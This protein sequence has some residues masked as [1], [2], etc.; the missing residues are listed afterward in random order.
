MAY[1]YGRAQ[2]EKVEKIRKEYLLR[3]RKMRL[4]HLEWLETLYAINGDDD[5]MLRGDQIV[6]LARIRSEEIDGVR[7]SHNYMFQSLRT[8]LANAM[9]NAP[10]PVIT[11]GRPGRDSRQMARACERLLSYF[12]HDKHYDDAVKTA[13]SWTFTCGIGF[14][15][16]MWDMDAKDPEYVPKTDSDGNVIY[17]TEK[18]VMTGADGQ[19]ALSPY[20]TPLTEDVMIPQGEYKLLGDLKYYAPS[21]FDVF[22]QQVRRWPDVKNVITRSYMNKDTMKDLFGSKAKDLYPDVSTDDFIT[23]DDYD[24]V[25][26]RNRED[27]LVLC[28]SYYERPSLEHPD[29]KYCVIANEKIIYEEDLPGKRLPIFPVYDHESPSH[30]WGESALR[31]AVQV[32]RDINAAES[33]L[34]TDRRMHAHPR[35]VAQ[36]GSL[37]KGVTRVP[38]IP[39]AVM[40]V[41]PDAKFAP[42]F[43]TAPPLPSWVERAPDRLKRVMDD[44]TGTHGVMKGDQKG[45]MSGRQASVIM[46]ADRAK[47]GPTIQ[48]LAAAVEYTS[49][50]ALTLWKEFGPEQETI[51]I[52]G[53]IGT[54][55]DIM[56][57]YRDYLP[58]N[59]RVRIESSQL[60]PYNEEIRRQQINEAWQIGAIPD[61]NMFWKLQ[62]HG[63]MGRLLG[64]DEP[65]RARARFEND[66]LDKGQMMPV[67]QHE[68][69]SVHIDEHLER[70]RDPSWYMLTPQAQQAYRMHV[71]KHQALMQN[72]QNPVL[73][74]KSQMP[75]LVGENMAP[76][77]N[78]AQGAG[79][80]PGVNAGQEIK[81]GGG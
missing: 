3:R 30:L 33:D 56:V 77:M 43:L 64:N 54:P 34:K 22:P 13:L 20:G 41:R 2:D 79:T 73:A 46:A 25:K 40:E 72:V 59:I 7:V 71:A 65:S 6:D 67:E 74:G 57:F 17:K 19:M 36:Q 75:D 27:E 28:L 78:G 5:K 23:F 16:S 51:D 11:L 49:E 76:T 38:N 18:R 9:Q 53:P 44:I 45:I 29:G 32:Q 39:G 50:L 15:G 48:S 14:L 12:Y 47:W 42:Q 52:Y 37:V 55:T 63:E 68:Q 69:H 66:M 10:Q 31:Q 60:M 58:D 8:M 61:I 24:S 26:D 81:M 35:L 21:P 62:R 1:R 70:M 4:R 80:N